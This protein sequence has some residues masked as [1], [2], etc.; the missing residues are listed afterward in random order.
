LPGLMLPRFDAGLGSGHGIVP[1]VSL[2]VLGFGSAA[3]AA[4]GRTRREV[5]RACI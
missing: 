2:K 1:V 5:G 3:A 4:S